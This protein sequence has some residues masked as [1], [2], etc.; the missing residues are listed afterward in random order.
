MQARVI[1]WTGHRPDL[2]L[3]PE[4]ARTAVEDTAE[5]LKAE[6]FLVGGQRGVDTWAAQA[7]GRLGVPFTL[8]LPLEVE[9]FTAAW[10]A[11]DRCLLEQTMGW[12]AEVRVMGGQ[13]EAQAYTERNRFLATSADLLVAVWTGRA[14]GG[15]AETL[16]FARAAGVPIHEVR[17]PASPSGT[18]ASG[19]GL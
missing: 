8:V 12:A 4:A 16:A 15:T 14:G 7:A 17:L 19:R 18:Q 2:F 10:S 9:A 5:K 6:R 11:D 3:D 13:V 1:A